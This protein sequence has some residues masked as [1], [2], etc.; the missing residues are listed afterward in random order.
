VV[1]QNK[2]CRNCHALGNEGGRRGPDLDGVGIRL[3]RDEL[4]TQVIRGSGDM[5]AYGKQVSPAEVAALVAFLQTLRPA[6]D[7]VARPPVVAKP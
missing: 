5:P 1:L 7:P 2:N 6:G 3:T 4:I